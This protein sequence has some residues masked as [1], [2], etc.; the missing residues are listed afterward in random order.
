MVWGSGFHERLVVISLRTAI[1]VVVMAVLLAL[2]SWAANAAVVVLK[3]GDQVTGQIV[4]MQD[5]KLEID[6]EDSSDIVIIKWDMVRSIR[7]EREM[8]IKL[9]SE[10]DLPEHVGERVDMDLGHWL[11]VIVEPNS[12]AGPVVIK[13]AKVT[14]AP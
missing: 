14:A 8:S 2:T 5:N 1:G 10:I 13:V 9:F 6:S 4:K 11:A 7:T 3:N 12:G